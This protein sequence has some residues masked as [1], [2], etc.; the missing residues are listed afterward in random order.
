MAKGQ[1]KRFSNW[2][3][4][5]SLQKG[6]THHK[7]MIS[8]TQQLRMAEISGIYFFTLNTTASGVRSHKSHI[9]SFPQH[10]TSPPKPKYLHCNSG[11]LLERPPQGAREGLKAQNSTTR[12][13]LT[14][15]HQAAGCCVF[16]EKH[17]GPLFWKRRK[18]SAM[19]LWF[20]WGCCSRTCALAPQQHSHDKSNNWCLVPRDH[21][22]S[23]C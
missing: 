15:R 21:K 14:A 10:L 6:G 23:F 19:K 17:R 13:V 4:W 3:T 9:A 2:S 16:E 5:D 18:L 11:C 1:V 12:V 22:R 7:T 20:H 8:F